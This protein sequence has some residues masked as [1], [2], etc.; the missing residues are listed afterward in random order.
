M[1]NAN[2]FISRGAIP[3]LLVAYAIF[4]WIDHT[5]GT[6][7]RDAD[8][9]VH[10]QNVANSRSVDALVFG[11]SNAAYSLSAEDLSYK[12]GLSWYNASLDGELFTA[13]KYENFVRQL[14]ARIDRTKV[15][16]VVYSNI[17]PYVI[18][19]IARAKSTNGAK[20]VNGR[21]IKPIRSVLLYIAQ[22][23]S[24]RL[25]QVSHRSQHNSPG[26]IDSERQRDNFGDIVFGTVK[27]QFAE[28]P[29]HEREDVDASADFLVDEAIFY[30]SVFPNASI[31]IVLPSEYYG[32]ASFDDS[33]FEEDLRTKFY[34]LL[35]Q[36][37][38]FE[39][40]VKIIF[41]PP[42]TSITQ[43]C[44][45]QRHADEDG[46]AWRTENLIEDIQPTISRHRT[47][48]H[49]QVNHL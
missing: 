25:R 38:H 35:R 3:L 33:I 5:Y 2:R 23:I 34:G 20:K 45:N 37:Y 18:G 16:Y 49:G 8:V 26:D 4:I 11:G 19:D 24:G 40:R 27:C 22:Y 1:V 29:W 44:D 17:F 31:L 15:R 41:Q 46:R 9:K 12:T 39:G 30:A 48:L 7:Y 21:G 14:S 6:R 36:K 42:Y 10:L 43:V 32:V 28:T 13:D 47:F